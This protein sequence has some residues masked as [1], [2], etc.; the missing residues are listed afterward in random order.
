[1]THAAAIFDLDRT[2]LHRGSAPILRARLRDVGL[3]TRAIP[4]EG[5]VFGLFDVVGETY[6]SLALV[7]QAPRFARGWPVADVRRAG[8]LAAAELEG[9]VHPE[10]EPVLDAHHA[11]GRVVALATGAPHDLVAPFA[12]LLGVD[13]LLATRLGVGADGRYDGTL[14]G[15]VVWGRGKLA[16]VRAWAEGRAIDLAESWAYS[17]SFYD[18]PLLVAVGHP[19]AWNPDVRLAAIATLRGWPVRRP[20]RPP[21]AATS[22][23]ADGSG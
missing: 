7:R 9:M 3:A 10:I 6:P 15:A 11:A 21:P 13:T 20:R 8:E 17:D 18:L 16:A 22:P 23:P 2:L 4:G 5:L 12:A 14:D 19:V 1:M